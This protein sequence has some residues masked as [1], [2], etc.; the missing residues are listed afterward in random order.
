MATRDIAFLAS[1][2]CDLRPDTEID[3]IVLH[4]ISLPDGEFSMQH[5]SDFFLGKL[6]ISAHPSFKDLQGVCVSAH[7]VVDRDGHISQFVPIE[8][9]AWHAGESEWLGREICND[10]SIGIEMIGDERKPFTRQQYTETARLCRSLIAQYPA[11]N[12]SRIVGHQDIAPSRKW[13]PGKQFDWQ[14]FR[15]SFA[16][17]KILFSQFI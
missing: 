13:D 6:D 14:H 15:R 7:F 8:Q 10:Y 11:I 17:I 4:A 12:K 2:H 9:R 3:L 5:I 16:H 1:P